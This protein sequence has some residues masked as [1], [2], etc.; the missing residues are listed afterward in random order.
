MTHKAHKVAAGAV[1]VIGIILLI[2]GIIL[3]ELNVQH[4]RSQ[5]WYIWL[6]L[7]GGLIITLIGGIWLALSFH[8]PKHP[9]VVLY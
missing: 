9:E 6:L 7:I 1:I 4:S 3:F 5:A 8:R 2:I